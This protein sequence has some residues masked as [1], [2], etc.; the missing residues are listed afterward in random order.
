MRL[1]LAGGSGKVGTVAARRLKR[2][3]EVTVF[4]LSPPSVSGIDYIKRDLVNLEQVTAATT[5]A[6]AVVNL[7]AIRGSLGR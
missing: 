1:L 6:E 7:A 2:H 4:D 3:Q 5:G